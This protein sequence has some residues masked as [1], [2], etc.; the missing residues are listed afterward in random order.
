MR[1]CWGHLTLSSRTQNFCRDDRGCRWGHVG[2]RRLCQIFY[3]IFFCVLCFT[4]SQQMEK[5]TFCDFSLTC[6]GRISS[7]LVLWGESAWCVQ[8]CPWSQEV[9]WYHSWSYFTINHHVLNVLQLISVV[10]CHEMMKPP[11]STFALTEFRKSKAEKLFFM[12]QS[13]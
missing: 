5:M 12:P 2:I 11:G 1:G 10:L 13:R 6:P 9:D 4:W 8:A 7:W 3:H